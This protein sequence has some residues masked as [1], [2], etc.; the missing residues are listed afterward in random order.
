MSV[1]VVKRR[2]RA[3]SCGTRTHFKSIL[4]SVYAHAVYDRVETTAQNSLVRG[5]VVVARELLML[6]LCVCGTR[7]GVTT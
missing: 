5:G 6:L 7:G 3:K 1:P 4:V 2:I